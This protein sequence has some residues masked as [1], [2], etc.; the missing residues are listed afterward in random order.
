MDRIPASSGDENAAPTNH[1][2]RA[3]SPTNDGALTVTKLYKPRPPPSYNTKCCVPL[4]KHNNKNYSGAFK[5][6]PPGAQSTPKRSMK[7]EMLLTLAKKDCIRKEWL[8]RLKLR[9]RMKNPMR[10]DL[11]ICQEHELEV[12]TKTVYYCYY[13]DSEEGGDREEIADTLQITFPTIK[14]QSLIESTTD[15]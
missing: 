1:V 12:V 4:C 5:R 13:V 9:K 8:K 3:H 14:V 2:N 7:K 15:H 10:A 11:R 6:L